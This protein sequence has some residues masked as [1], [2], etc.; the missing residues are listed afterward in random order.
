M[1]PFFTFSIWDD[2]PKGPGTPFSHPGSVVWQYTIANNDGNFVGWDY[3]PT[4]ETYDACFEYYVTLPQTQWFYQDPK[5][6]TNV[7]WLSIAAPPQ[8]PNDTPWGWKTVP[9]N[10]NAPSPDAA[11]R[12][13]Q[14]LHPFVGSTY[15]LGQELDY[16]TNGNPW[17]LAF[18]LISVQTTNTVVA[19]WLQVPDLRV[20][21]VEVAS[22]L[23]RRRPD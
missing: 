8:T 2:V 19:K 6:G 16:P 10:T 22:A 5:S 15:V 21:E 4:T 1:P 20:Q 23:R 11:V 12:I 18:E 3:D 14:P 9:H 7:Y 17:D 13:F